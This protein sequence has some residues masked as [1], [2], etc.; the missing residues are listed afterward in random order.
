MYEGSGR[1]K[2]DGRGRRT[3]PGMKKREDERGWEGQEDRPWYEGKGRM[4]EDGRG[5]RTGPGMKEEG[6]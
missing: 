2:E 6:G 3:G 5:R 1:M 4:K